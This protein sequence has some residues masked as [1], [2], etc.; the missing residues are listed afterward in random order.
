MK[1]GY[2]IIYVPDVVKAMTFYEVAFGLNRK[3]LHES[4][5]YGEMETGSTALAFANEQFVSTSGCVRPNRSND[6]AAGVEFAFV[7]PIVLE[8]IRRACDSGAT[9]IQ[10]PEIKLL[11]SSSVVCSRFER[12]TDRYLLGVRANLVSCDL[13][14][15]KWRW[16]ND[17]ESSRGEKLAKQW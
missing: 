9:S 12:S 14:F 13:F 16:C 1:F 7:A 6:L 15:C 3:F 11:G 10:E 5:M 17:G 2:A 8:A 4:R